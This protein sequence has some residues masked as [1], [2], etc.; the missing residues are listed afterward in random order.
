[1]ADQLQL[2]AEALVT[3]HS[4]PPADIAGIAVPPD[5][6]AAMTVQGEVARRLSTGVAGWKVAIRP[7][8]AAVAAPLLAPITG[9][10]SEF[11][12]AQTGFLGIEVEIGLRLKADLPPR[13]SQAYTREDVLAATDMVFAGIEVVA[14]RVP[15]YLQA[16]F[17]LALA[18]NMANGG[19]AI[20][21]GVTEWSKLD[22]AALMTRIRV[23]GKEV[24][25]LRGG[26]GNG[27]PLIPV[28]AYASAQFDKLG[29]LR[30]GQ[31]ITTGTLCGLMPV[32]LPAMI[33]AE[34]EGIGAARLHL[35]AKM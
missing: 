17:P 31:I 33:E 4:H 20:G 35:Q 26:H 30:A 34:I 3:A 23:D 13:G 18:D 12:I 21:S 16:P 28:V 22:L 27:D 1:M 10:M 11:K 6:A 9:T 15:G 32:A 2:L 24:H 25:A 8:G 5:N 14:A 29:G 19:Y 7:E